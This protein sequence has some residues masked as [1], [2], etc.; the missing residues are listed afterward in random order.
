MS[1]DRIDCGG[2]AILIRTS[3]REDY[4]SERGAAGDAGARPDQSARLNRQSAA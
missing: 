1:D 4:V 3:H 2:L